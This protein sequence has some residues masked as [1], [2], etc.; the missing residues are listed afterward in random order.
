MG[1]VESFNEP[2][3]AIFIINDRRIKLDNVR[4]FCA[5]ERVVSYPNRALGGKGPRVLY[6]P[7]GDW[8]GSFR[9]EDE[10]VAALLNKAVNDMI[11]VTLY[12]YFPLPNGE[13]GTSEYE[14]VILRKN[15]AV[16]FIFSAGHRE[17]VV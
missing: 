5:K 14:N 3:T 15:S 4:D 11:S 7:M 10:K 6:R 9:V 12:V 1:R 2:V 8:T 16:D 17:R 13:R